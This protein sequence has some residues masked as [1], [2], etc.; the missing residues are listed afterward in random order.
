MIRATHQICRGILLATLTSF[1]LANA[2]STGTVQTDFGGREGIRGTALQ[3]DGKLVAAGF[4]YGTSTDNSFALARYGTDGKLDATFGIG[5]KVLTTTFAASSGYAAQAEATA[6]AIQA[7]GKI[8]A[9]GFTYSED[10]ALARYNTNGSLDTTFG[11]GGK[12]I[13]NWG[14]LNGNRLRA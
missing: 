6:V 12:V 11:S 9:A 1:N 7:D 8:V 2:A 10:I 14:S 4:F 3:A 5:G 13:T